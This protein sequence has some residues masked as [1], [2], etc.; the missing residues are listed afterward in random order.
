[1]K[2]SCFHFSFRFVGMGTIG[3]HDIDMKMADNIISI[4]G[5]NPKNLKN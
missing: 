5:S 1:M 4:M 3:K 2:T